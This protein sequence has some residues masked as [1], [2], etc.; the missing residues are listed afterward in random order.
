LATSGFSWNT[1][2]LGYYDGTTYHAFL[3]KTARPGIENYSP[4]L[5]VSLLTQFTRDY[6]MRLWA[7]RLGT[8]KQPQFQGYIEEFMDF[9]QSGSLIAVW[10]NVN[11]AAQITHSFT[12]ITVPS[13]AYAG[14]ASLSSGTAG[15]LVAGQIIR[16]TATG[17][18]I[19]GVTV[20][21]LISGVTYYVG[22]VKSGAA[23]ANETVSSVARHRTFYSTITA[24]YTDTTFPTTLYSS[25]DAGYQNYE[26]ALNPEL[27]LPQPTPTPTLN[28][29]AQQDDITT[30]IDNPWTTS[31][32]DLVLTTISENQIEV[33]QNIDNF[34]VKKEWINYLR[35]PILVS[36]YMNVSCDLPEFTHDEIVSMTAN[37]LLEEFE[38]GRYQTHQQTVASNE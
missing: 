21:T 11:T 26:V 14:M 7:N 18:V 22:I 37:Y 2:E 30:A 9:Y 25:V 5:D 33:Y 17:Q 29:L 15:V 38:S 8:N 24:I 19:F 23:P 10:K 6:M 31:G 1:S 3:G 4:T 35:L 12:Y 27:A 20:V 34:I 36:N 13:G 28:H 32:P 16:F